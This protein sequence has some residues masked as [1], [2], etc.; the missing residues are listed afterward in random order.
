MTDLRD[1]IVLVTGA[2]SGYGEATARLL[3]AHG[4]TLLL[5]GRRQERLNALVAELG[6]R[7]WPLCFDV[8]DRAAVDAA[9]DSL[10][11]ALTRVWGLVNNAGLALGLEPA[12]LA[13]LE[14]WETMVQTNILGVLYMTRKLLP[15]L[16]EQ[17]TGH[18]V[19]IGSV[20]GSYPYPGGNVY[21]ATKAFVHQLSLNLRADLHGTGVRV[22]SIEPG[23]SH[24]EFSLVRFKGNAALAEKPYQGLT[25]LSGDDI[26]ECVRW[27]LTQP[28]HVNINRIEIMPTA[29]A[30][31]P[32]TF[33]RG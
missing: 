14:D 16:I 25:P 4:A 12:A 8:R 33:H 1:R 9:I 11:P 15:R 21:G 7:A 26:A 27:A 18:V 2:T 20:A 23:L 29:Q 28:A 30:F 5:T 6:E 24:T 13:N 22:T 17:R 3:H 32:F 19:N 31:G 10:P